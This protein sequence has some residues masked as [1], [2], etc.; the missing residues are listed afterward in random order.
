MIPSSDLQIRYRNDAARLG[1]QSHQTPDVDATLLPEHL[2]P[3]LAM[4]VQ[5]LW[6]GHTRRWMSRCETTL[7][8]E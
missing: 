2:E 5:G 6:R 3:S 4:N 8:P 1:G 7:S